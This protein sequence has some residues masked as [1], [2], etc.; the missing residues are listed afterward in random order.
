MAVASPFDGRRFSRPSPVAVGLGASVVL[1]VVAVVWGRALVR[2]D[3]RIAL[4]AAPFFGRWRWEPT[5]W[6]LIAAAL[7]VVVVAGWPLA[8]R[9]LP[10][11][12]LCLASWAATAAWA[13]A[14]ALG[15]GP[16]DIARPLTTEFEYLVVVPG[17]DDIGAFW[18]TFLE[19]I[20]GYP[21]HVRGHP[22]GPVGGLWMLERVGLGGA[23]PAAVLVVGVG[24]SASLAALWTARAVAG[25]AVARR[26]AVFVP[27]VPAVMWLATSMDAAFCG[28]AAWSIATG[29]VAS[30]RAGPRADALAAAS[31]LLAGLL[32]LLTYS[33]VLFVTPALVA[34]FVARRWRLVALAAAA[35][36]LVLAMSAAGGFW[37]LDGVV[38]VRRQYLSS[39]ARFRPYEYF[40]VANVAVLAVVLGP[41]PV[42]A[43][44]RRLPAGV[45]LLV[46]STLASLLVADLS[47]LSKAEVERIWLPFIPWLALATAAVPSRQRLWL[48]AQVG[49]G[50]ALE[51]ALPRAVVTD[52]H[53]ALSGR[54]RSAVTDSPTAIITENAKPPRR[55]MPRTLSS[56]SETIRL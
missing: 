9:R 52:L 6:F 18:R 49:T 12:W 47:G 15:E 16:A 43:M 30:R 4:G 17:I 41:A 14:L 33:A 19:R 50:L 44:F 32:L 2:T 28:I 55:S 53:S 29:V 10:W 35:G 45:S 38:E 11:P 46:Y 48:G 34:G 8:A 1:V 3:G 5:W 20:D 25:E 21:V 31:G 39:V 22:P 40:V 7:A 51:L 42:G 24:T 13:I 27:F 36:A 23:W 37:W 54:A 26:A 56:G